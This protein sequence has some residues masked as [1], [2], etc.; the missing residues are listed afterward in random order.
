MKYRIKYETDFELNNQLVHIQVFPWYSNSITISIHVDFKRICLTFYKYFE[1]YIF[2][3]RIIINKSDIRIMDEVIK[4]LIE[5]DFI[6]RIN[7]IKYK[8]TKSFELKII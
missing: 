3:S 1:T 5:N 6:Q 8:L 4:I 7:Q 2:D